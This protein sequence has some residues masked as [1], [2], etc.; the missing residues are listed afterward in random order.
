MEK[1]PGDVKKPGDLGMQ[2]RFSAKQ[3]Q[4]FDFSVRQFGKSRAIPLEGFNVMT[5]FVGE[6]REVVTMFAPQ[7]AMIGKMHFKS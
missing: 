3:I 4:Q 6:R 2:Q 5:V 7:V 1:S